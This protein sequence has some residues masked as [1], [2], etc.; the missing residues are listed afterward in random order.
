LEGKKKMQTAKLLKTDSYNQDV[1]AG[2]PPIKAAP[3]FGQRLAAARKSRAWSQTKLAEKLDTN[4][5]VIDYYERRAVNPSISF[6]Q[7]AAEVLGIPVA[8]LV[9]GDFKAERSRPG[10]TPQLALRMEQIRRL[11]RKQQ[12]F[13]IRLIDTVLEQA[14]KA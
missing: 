8:E 5:K 11:P 6:I 3:L 1:M 9:G 10:P 14:G 2:R 4:Q 12:E 7:R 13:M